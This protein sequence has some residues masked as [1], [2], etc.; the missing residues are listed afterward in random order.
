MNTYPIC[1]TPLRRSAQRFA[2]LQKSRQYHR[3]YV[4]IHIRYAFRAGAE[5]RTLACEQALRAG[6]L[7][8]RGGKGKESLQLLLWN[9]NICIEKV[10]AKCWLADMTLVV[11]SLPLARAFTCFSMFVKFALVSASRWLAEIWQLSRRGATGELEAEFKFQRSSCKLSFL[12]P[13]RRQSAPESLL[14]GLEY[15][16]ALPAQRKRLK[17]T[18]NTCPC[19]SNC[20]FLWRNVVAVPRRTNRHCDGSWFPCGLHH[21]YYPLCFFAILK[22]LREEGWEAIKTEVTEK[23][24]RGEEWEAIKTGHR[25]TPERRGVK[26]YKNRSPRNSWEES[27][28]KL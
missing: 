16:M 28:E 22:E 8:R 10:Y 5:A 11:T 6:A 27:G 13:P 7:W 19:K 3:S 14:A 21:L 18:N 24:L 17:Q 4:W 12:F 20:A 23:L 26:S 9:L 25:Q 2:P 15:L 1:D